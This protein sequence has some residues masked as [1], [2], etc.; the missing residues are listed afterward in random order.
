ML[1]EL[2]I[3]KQEMLYISKTSKSNKASLYKLFNT[4]LGYL[5]PCTKT[6]IAYTFT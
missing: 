2:Y 1:K 4:I 3:I 5:K 6:T